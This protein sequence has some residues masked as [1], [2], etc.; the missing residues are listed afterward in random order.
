RIIELGLDP[1]KICNP[2][3]VSTQSL[4]SNTPRGKK[5]TV[6]CRGL[7]KAGTRCRHMTSLANGYCYQHNPDK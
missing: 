7:T 6:Q 4:S 2:Q 1:C 3:V 5:E